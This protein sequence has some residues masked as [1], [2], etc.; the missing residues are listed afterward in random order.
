MPNIS[1]SDKEL[2]ESN[3]G[4]MSQIVE[5]FT[6]QIAKRFFKESHYHAGVIYD[7]KWLH[8]SIRLEKLVNPEPYIMKIIDYQCPDDQQTY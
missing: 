2:I 3:G 5:C 7:V 1:D 4:L 8:E 6:I